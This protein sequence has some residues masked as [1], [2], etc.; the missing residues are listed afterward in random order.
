MRRKPIGIMPHFLWRELVVKARIEELK[1]A[2]ERY[3]EAN[4][5]RPTEWYAEMYSLQFYLD[6]LG[7]NR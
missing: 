4:L 2:I 7:G 3:S 6:S 5:P 1:Q